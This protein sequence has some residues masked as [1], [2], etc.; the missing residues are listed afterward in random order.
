[1]CSIE[2][3]ILK[4]KRIDL[5]TS[6]AAYKSNEVVIKEY[7]TNNIPS[8]ERRVSLDGPAAQTTQ[9][10][11]FSIPDMIQKE[12]GVYEYSLEIGYK[13]GVQ[14]QIQGMIDNLNKEYRAF[15]YYYNFCNTPDIF[16]ETI[17]RFKNESLEEFTYFDELAQVS[18]TI[19]DITDF[20]VSGVTYKAVLNQI[21]NHSTT[22]TVNVV[23]S[24]L[25][26][27]NGT[28]KSVS[29]VLKLYDNLIKQLG[30]TVVT[31]P[32][33]NN[34][35]NEKNGSPVQDTYSSTRL[36]SIVIKKTFNNLLD[37]T[38]PYRFE[39]LN[40]TKRELGRSVTVDS[41]PFIYEIIKTELVEKK[42]RNSFS[43]NYIKNPGTYRKDFYD[44][45]GNLFG[46]LTNLKI[47]RH[48]ELSQEAVNTLSRRELP[49][50]FERYDPSSLQQLGQ[51]VLDTSVTDQ[52]EI[53]AINRLY[54]T[55]LGPTISSDNE[56]TDFIIDSSNKENIFWSIRPNSAVVSGRE[57]SGLFAGC[58]IDK[59]DIN[60]MPNQLKSL[61]RK[62]TTTLTTIGTMASMG[63]AEIRL[64]YEL[65]KSIVHLIGFQYDSQNGIFNLQEEYWM[66]LTNV[67]DASF[68]NGAPLFCKLKDYDNQYIK[69]KFNKTLK[70][71]VTNEYFFLT[72]NVDDNGRIVNGATNMSKDMYN[73]RC[74]IETKAFFDGEEEPSVDV[75]L[76]GSV[77]NRLDSV[78][79]NKYSFLS[80]Y[81][82][83][84]D[85]NFKTINPF[86]MEQLPASP[87]TSI[88]INNRYIGFVPDYTRSRSF[89]TNVRRTL[90]ASLHSF[91]LPLGGLLR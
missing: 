88:P 10:R 52:L 72:N 18:G 43:Q 51:S 66:K 38:P 17:Q 21:Y 68:V 26:R 84:M 39:Y 60:K 74:L 8:I 75:V 73:S 7:Y 59:D 54:L 76:G 14:E 67:R 41:D 69:Y 47:S 71:G 40:H 45:I 37:L 22:E 79:K 65:I 11:L 80:P 62:K 91:N 53:D 33:V 5:D 24:W 48:I 9:L 1:M 58:T 29:Y 23:N 34:S 50:F 81:G 78:S 2:K 46:D 6:L 63:D 77:M 85:N 13:D 61:L 27:I 64:K 12:P 87:V 28:P 16:N 49:N 89:R 32:F 31:T 42:L 57:I 25:D 35:L 30:K 4:C 70:S 55:L 83:Y 56:Y 20:S 82:F 19:D 44:R 86:H 3:I 36:N 15:L 90:A